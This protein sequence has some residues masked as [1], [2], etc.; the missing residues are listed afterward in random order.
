MNVPV[1][2]YSNYS[3]PLPPVQ[4]VPVAVT[5]AFDSPISNFNAFVPSGDALPAL[6]VAPRSAPASFDA[7]APVAFSAPANFGSAETATTATTTGLVPSTGA[8][9][10]T[11]SR[12]ASVPPVVAAVPEAAPVVSGTNSAKTPVL[13]GEALPNPAL[14]SVVSAPSTQGTPTLQPETVKNPNLPPILGIVSGGENPPAGSTNL[15]IASAGSEGVLG[16][17][18]DIVQTYEETLWSLAL[19]VPGT[20]DAYQLN[21]SLPAKKDTQNYSGELEIKKSTQEEPDKL[22]D[23]GEDCNGLDLV[24]RVLQCGVMTEENLRTD[25][26]SPSEDVD[27]AITNMYN[28]LYQNKVGLEVCSNPQYR[29]F[30]VSNDM[31]IQFAGFPLVV[32]GLYQAFFLPTESIDRDRMG[33]SALNG[34]VS[35]QNNR[36]LWDANSR[37]PVQKHRIRVVPAP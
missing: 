20:S 21:F 19:H 22:V 11:T 12:V 9:A 4:E 29:D 30:Q 14:A 6:P 7:P 37:S 10:V 23:C 25:F 18:P 31:K 1:N 5:Q 15:T 35:L 34:A 3:V 16:S 26:A 28:K 33:P 36:E 13:A 8:P 32:D 24:V 17:S 27:A 2:S